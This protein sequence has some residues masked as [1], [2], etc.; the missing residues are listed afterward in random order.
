MMGRVRLFT[1]W[2]AAIL[3]GC[4]PATRRAE[5]P[6][7][8][9][10]AEPWYAQTVAQVV[11]L[12]QDADSLINKRKPDE[13]AARITEAQ[14][15]M[16]KLLSVPNPTFE[17]MAVVS[18]LDEMYGR[19]LLHNHHY[20]WARLQFQK[21]VARWRNWSPPTEESRRRLKEAQA[22]IMEVDRQL[23]K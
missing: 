16:A 1:L 19:M 23:A 17:A 9:P 3:I 13:A 22:A 20:G 14:P 8:D 12:R 18:D 11:A 7:P 21:N 6:K 5:T 10:T 2:L 4:A 15:L